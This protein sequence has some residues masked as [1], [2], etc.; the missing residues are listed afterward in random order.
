MTE[1]SESRNNAGDAKPSDEA[2]CLVPP[3][4]IF[5]RY[6]NTRCQVARLSL[7]T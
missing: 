5:P 6:H 2:N 4:A 7:A 3:E 1:T